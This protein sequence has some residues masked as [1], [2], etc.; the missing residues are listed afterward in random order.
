MRVIQVGVGGFGTG[1]LYAVKECGFE[2]AALV[3]PSAEALENAGQI[4]GVPAELRF[5]NLED[6]LKS[7]K[8]DGLLNV[9][10]APF[11]LTTTLQAIDAG[12][13][14]LI[15]KPMAESME[16]AQAMV[17]DAKECERVLMVTQQYRYQDQPRKLRQMI[18]EGAVGAIDHV[19]VEFQIQGVLSGWRQVMRHP[20]LMDMAI[21]HFDLM[22]YLLGRE[23]KTVQAHTWNP[24]VSNTRGD[25]NACVWLEFEDGPRVNYTGCFASPGQDTGWNGRWNITGTRGSLVWNPRDDWGPIRI[26]HQNADLSQYTSSHFFTPLPEIWGDPVWA[27][28]IGATGHHYDLYHWRACIEQGVEPETSGRDNL[29]TLAM[30]FAAME[31]ADT[32]RTI[33]VPRD[34]ET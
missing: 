9:T 2:H 33:D 30:T 24:K 15:E 21:H 11:H 3:D 31:S 12:L 1:W 16:A 29:H 22:R 4:T 14:V 23:A 26:F 25:M 27:E 8:A 20:F 19:I 7:V 10:P 28:S 6:A 17:R 5:T 32:G 34:V 18:A 13:H